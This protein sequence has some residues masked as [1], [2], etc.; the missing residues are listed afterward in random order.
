VDKTYSIEQIKKAYWLS[1]HKSGE[2]WFNYLGDEEENT[3]CTEWNW[4]EFEE[5]L[6]QT[7]CNHEHWTTDGWGGKMCVDCGKYSPTG[8]LSA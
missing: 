5:N 1:F 2:L 4:R 7:D 3:S 8:D 6:E